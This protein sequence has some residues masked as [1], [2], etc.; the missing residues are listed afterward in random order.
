MEKI[1]IP[2]EKKR[3][4]RELGAYFDRQTREWFIPDNT[5]EENATKLRTLIFN[6]EPEIVSLEE[7]N[8]YAVCENVQS[9]SY[10]AY[11]NDDFDWSFVESCEDNLK[12]AIAVKEH[13]MPSNEQIRIQILRKLGSKIPGTFPITYDAMCEYS[14]KFSQMYGEELVSNLLH[15]CITGSRHYSEDIRLSDLPEEYKLLLMFV[16]PL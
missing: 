3:Q 16:L 10:T 13:G 6:N 15:Q 4:A 12:V 14:E 5:K 8:E 11:E 9:F 2:F 7:N 1:E